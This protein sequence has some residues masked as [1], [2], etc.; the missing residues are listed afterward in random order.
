MMFNES[1]QMNESRACCAFGISRI[2]VAAWR[3][4][5]QTIE[6]YNSG[7]GRPGSKY[8]HQLPS[9]RTSAPLQ[10]GQALPERLEAPEEEKSLPRPSLCCTAATMSCRAAISRSSALVTLVSVAQRPWPSLR[11]MSGGSS[12]SDLRQPQ[13][14]PALPR[15]VGKAKLAEDVQREFR[16][17]VD[18]DE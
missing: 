2:P 3:S 15:A 5:S 16:E 4:I 6:T 10:N 7:C 11:K 1:T 9:D 13:R 12:R 18:A 8:R 17:R 14:R